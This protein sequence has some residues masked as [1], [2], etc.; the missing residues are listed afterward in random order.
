MG[1]L[2]KNPYISK[3]GIYVKATDTSVFRKIE[4][5][6]QSLPDFNWKILLLHD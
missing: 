4:I 5:S 2:N 1:I 6:M 3:S